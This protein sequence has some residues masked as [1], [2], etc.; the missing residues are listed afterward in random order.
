[1]DIIPRELEVF[2][3]K[4]I[5]QCGQNPNPFR[6]ILIQANQTLAD[7]ASEIVYSFGYDNDHLYRFYNKGEYHS[8]EI[9]EMSDE[10]GE[11]DYFEEGA[12]DVCETRISEAFPEKG[13]KLNFLY[14]FGDCNYF[15]IRLEKIVAPLKNKQYPCVIDKKGKVPAQYGW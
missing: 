7:L 3:F 1:M 5:F 9:Y 4:I 2:Q 15:S 14:D 6:R 11:V 8:T 13:K 12:K 10:N